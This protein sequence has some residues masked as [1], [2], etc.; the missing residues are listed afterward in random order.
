MAHEVS[1][2]EITA[3]ILPSL[4][5]DSDADAAL[6]PHSLSLI[7]RLPSVDV[8]VV[9]PLPWATAALTAICLS[10]ARGGQIVCLCSTEA[11]SGHETAAMSTPMR[12][13]EAR[14]V[15][16]RHG[17]AGPDGLQPHG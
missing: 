10:A 1:A 13:S 6:S 11:R 8:S 9:P 2:E 3:S 7:S 17:Q 15:R 12:H 16:A 4:T 5:L 14:M